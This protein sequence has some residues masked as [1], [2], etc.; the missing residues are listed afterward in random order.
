[1]NLD[2]SRLWE[3]FS[4]AGLIFGPVALA[5]NWQNLPA[6]VPIHYG[7]LG[8]PDS[9]GPKETLLILPVLSFVLYAVLSYGQ[10]RPERSNVPWKINDANRAQTYALVKQLLT[11]EKLVVVVMLSYL[12]WAGVSIALQHSQGLGVWFA[13]ITLVAMFSPLLF[14]YVLGDKLKHAK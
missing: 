12:Q 11:W 2:S 8:N 1:M 6:Q 10:R 5:Q 9:Y 14:F 13:P 7:L 3:N 4:L